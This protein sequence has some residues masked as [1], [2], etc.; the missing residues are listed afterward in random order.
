[1][2]GAGVHKTT[3]WLPCP[4]L[5]CPALR[6]YVSLIYRAG[7]LRTILCDI[8]RYLSRLDVGRRYGVQAVH[9]L[10]KL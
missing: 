6:E 3:T 9:P 7:I 1:M 2:R 5:P 4:A 8:R 10:H